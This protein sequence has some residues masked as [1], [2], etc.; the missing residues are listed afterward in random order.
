MAISLTAKVRYGC[1]RAH[2]LLGGRLVRAVADKALKM[3]NKPAKQQTKRRKH[4]I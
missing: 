3:Q 4:S 1:H 2:D